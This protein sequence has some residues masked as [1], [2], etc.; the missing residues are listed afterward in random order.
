MLF[1]CTGGGA[2]KGGGTGGTGDVPLEPGATVTLALSNTQSAELNSVESELAPGMTSADFAARYP[3][4]FTSSLGYDA[5]TAVGLDVISAAMALDPGELGKIAENGFVISKLQEYPSFVYGYQ[6]IYMHDLPVY[7]SA[8][9][10]LDAVHRSYDDILK[11]IESALLTTEATGMLSGMRSHLA[12]ISDATVRADCDFYLTVAAS[13]LAGNVLSPTAGADASAVANFVTK[14]TAADGIDSVTLFGVAREIDFSQFKPRGHYA[15]DPVLENY[16]RAMM[17]LGRIDFRLI[18][19]LGDG[20]QVFRRRQVDA[21]LALRGLMDAEVDAHWSL[22]DSIIHAF[23]GESDYMTPPEVDQLV[24]DV[25]GAAAIA[26]LD[27]KALA[28]AIIDGGYGNQL[29]ASDIIFKTDGGSPTLPLNTSFALLG[30]RYVIDSHVFSNVVWDRTAQMRMMPDPLDVAFAALNNDQA[31]QLLSPQLEQ[32]AYAPNLHDMRVIADHHPDTFWNANLY[33]QWLSSLRALSQTTTD[34]LPTVATT[35]AWGRRILSAQLASWAELRH[36]TIL[37][38]KQ[39]YTTGA[40]CDYPDAYVDPYPEFYAALGRF[41]DSGANIADL[42]SNAGQSTLGTQ[43]HDYFGQLS[44]VV[45]TLGEMAQ[46]E[47][48]G[49]PFNDA[50]IAFINESV[51]LATSGCTTDG[52]TGWYARLFFDNLASDDYDPTIADVHTQPTDEG[53]NV[54]GRVLHVGTARPRLMVVTTNG[55]SGPRAYAGVVFAYHEHITENF[56]RLDDE[57]WS[58]MLNSGEPDVSWVTPLLEP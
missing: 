9:S 31:G 34:G 8:D 14:A 4:S 54:V 16:F 30:Q 58:Q 57:G 25:G 11:A 17:W 38:A 44:S 12:S 29:I 2:D 28:Q 47:R 24:A 36:D 22:I 13:L 20:T 1:G 52:S 56:E 48:A 45:S 23:V 18:E 53:G 7:V 5:S 50:Q 39:S 15:G 27:D 3:V 46:Y 43:L 49:T 32:Y 10:I 21:M 40:G 42:V 37:Y 6:T 35:E 33:N 41:A 26:S 55:C 19:T 51:G